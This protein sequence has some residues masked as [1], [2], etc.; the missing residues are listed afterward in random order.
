[1]LVD[2]FLAVLFHVLSSL[3]V[4]CYLMIGATGSKMEAAGNGNEPLGM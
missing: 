2:F 3:L 4:V 1:M